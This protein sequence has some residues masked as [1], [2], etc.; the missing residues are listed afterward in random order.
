MAPDKPGVIQYHSIKLEILDAVTDKS[1]V[2]PSDKSCCRALP[3]ASTIELTAR[4]S[5]ILNINANIRAS[6]RN[7]NGGLFWNMSC[8]VT[9]IINKTSSHE[10]TKNINDRQEPLDRKPD[11]INWSNNLSV[12][13]LILLN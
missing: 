10:T 11:S 9:H 13:K 6:K 7:D 1:V 5:K 12:D 3:V 2:T 8:L 4:T